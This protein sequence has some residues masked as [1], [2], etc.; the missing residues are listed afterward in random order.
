MYI[1]IYISAESVSLC[2]TSGSNRV[3]GTDPMRIYQQHCALPI[4]G[5][6]LFEHYYEKTSLPIMSCNHHLQKKQNVIKQK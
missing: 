4:K 5:L 6:H 2:Q 3:N 1:S